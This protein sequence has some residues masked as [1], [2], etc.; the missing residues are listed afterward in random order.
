MVKAWGTR[1]QNATKGAIVG[2]SGTQDPRLLREFRA[3]KGLAELRQ[4]NK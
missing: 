1:T 4:P 3:D 2:C